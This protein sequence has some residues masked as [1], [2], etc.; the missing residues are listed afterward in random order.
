[1]LKRQNLRHALHFSIAARPALVARPTP[2]NSADELH[3][4]TSPTMS[5]NFKAALRAHLQTTAGA[6]NHSA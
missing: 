5:T 6:L 4:G 1:M 3:L 2:T